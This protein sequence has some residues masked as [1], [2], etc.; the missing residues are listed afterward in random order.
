MILYFGSNLTPFIGGA[1]SILI[2]IF[3]FVIRRKVWSAFAKASDPFWEILKSVSRRDIKPDSDTGAKIHYRAF[4]VFYN[5]MIIVL[6][7][8]G[9]VAIINK[10]H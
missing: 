5:L 1:L 6:F 3:L 10:T 2:G 9:L 7:L 8:A 4:K